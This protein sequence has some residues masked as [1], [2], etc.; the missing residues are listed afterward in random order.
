MADPS[1]RTTA[2]PPTRRVVDV[3]EALIARPGDRLGLSELARLC[4]ISKPTCLAV[5]TEL[6]DRGYLRLDPASKTYGLGPSLVAAGRAAEREVAVAPV[7]SERLQALS[8]R[9]GAMTLAAGRS[10]DQ[11]MILGATAPTGSSPA[12]R[13]GQ[14]FPFTLPTGVMFQLWQP[15]DVLARRSADHP[16]PFPGLST[17]EVQRMAAECRRT[18]YLVENLSPT[19]ERVY[20][21]IGRNGDSLP[22]DV[23][24]LIAEL[25]AGMRERRVL[26]HDD[27]V[28]D[29]EATHRVGAVSAPTFDAA[30]Q[31][32]L[33]LAIY[34]RAELTAADIAARGD[35]LR[36]VADELTIALGG[37]FPQV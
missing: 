11:F 3:L 10:G 13:V 19:L 25:L 26:F 34:A 17:P 36:T 23:L 9:F 5:L 31:Q 15:D 2:S 24:E 33:L 28:R 27:L 37:R 4:A 30:G 18:G 21:I 16:E 6:T 32:A 14:R 7:V 29:A 8:D 20:R 12:V 1:E 35:A 22:P